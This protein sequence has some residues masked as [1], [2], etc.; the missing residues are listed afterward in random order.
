[1]PWLHHYGEHRSLVD[2]YGP[3]ASVCCYARCIGKETAT[4]V[5]LTLSKRFHAGMSEAMLKVPP[6]VMQ[7][8]CPQ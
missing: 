6:L 2:S 7:V 3:Y 1:M 4:A 8:L 5:V